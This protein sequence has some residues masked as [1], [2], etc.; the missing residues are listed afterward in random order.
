VPLPRA[1]DMRQ[2]LAPLGLVVDHAGDGRKVGTRLALEMKGEVRVR[3]EVEQPLALARVGRAADEDAPSDVVEHDLE[4]PRL[5]AP[6]ADRGD[7]DGVPV[8]QRSIDRVF[9]YSHVYP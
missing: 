4:P 9:G 5:T 3:L 6:A 2:D 8:L 7:V 1:R